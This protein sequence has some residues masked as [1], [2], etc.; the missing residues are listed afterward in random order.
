MAPFKSVTAAELLTV[1]EAG[2]ARSLLTASGV[3]EKYVAA[4]AYV[5]NVRAVGDGAPEEQRSCPAMLLSTVAPPRR[6]DGRK[7]SI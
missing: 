4:V 1:V 6:A 2:P 5:V 3:A 7:S